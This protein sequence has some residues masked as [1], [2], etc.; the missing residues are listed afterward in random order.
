MGSYIVIFGP[1]FIVAH[2]LRQL[3]ALVRM[4]GSWY[5]GALNRQ[6]LANA[7]TPLLLFGAATIFLS[8]IKFSRKLPTCS[9][10]TNNKTSNF[11]GRK[12]RRWGYQKM[13][14]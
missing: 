14:M 1:V 4:I 5:L 3:N 6:S 12:M 11:L 8:G 13:V 7:N 9:E 10:S 2:N